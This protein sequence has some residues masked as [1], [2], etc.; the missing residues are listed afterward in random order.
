MPLN[1]EPAIDIPVQVRRALDSV[2]K[3]AER[4]RIA[5]SNPRARQYADR[6]EKVYKANLEAR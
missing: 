5:S 2:P 3:A 6:V 1:K 4:I